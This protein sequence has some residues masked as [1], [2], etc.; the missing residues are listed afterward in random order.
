MLLSMLRSRLSLPPRTKAGVALFLLATAGI[1]SACSTLKECAEVRGTKFGCAIGIDAL[2]GGSEADQLFRQE[3]I[4]NCACITP[5]DDW[6]MGNLFQAM[7]EERT[8]YFTLGIAKRYIDFAAQNNM[9]VNDHV[10]VWHGRID[11][12]GTDSPGRVT[13]WEMGQSDWQDWLEDYVTRVVETLTRYSIEE[14]GK[15]VIER[16]D[17]VSEAFVAPEVDG[18]QTG[19]GFNGPDGWRDT[20][21][22]RNIGTEYFSLS[23]QWARAA[24]ESLRAELGNV[25]GVPSLF[26]IDYSCELDNPK[27][28]LVLSRLT[29]RI[30]VGVPIDGFGFQAHISYIPNDFYESVGRNM[31]AFQVSNIPELAILEMDVFQAECR[32]PSYYEDQAYIYENFA[33]IAAGASKMKYFHTWYACPVV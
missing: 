3:V 7:S 19:D 21:W 33:M 18:D 15:N 30:S 4:Q 23:F 32:S 1:A 11:G 31:L 20:L 13:E 27:S 25:V 9:C 29:E 24:T 8:G 28:R 10:L 5:E 2:T 16:W 17:V 6:K 14:H 12:D 22:F 26:Y